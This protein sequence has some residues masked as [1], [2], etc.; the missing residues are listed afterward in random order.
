[1][2]DKIR[3]RQSCT[4]DLVLL[5]AG[6]IL[7]LLL[8]AM[9]ARGQDPMPPM[10]TDNQNAA[11]AIV[12][13]NPAPAPTI[14]G[15]IEEIAAAIGSSTNW[16]IVTGA[17]RGLKGN[18][19]VA[20]ADL[21]YSFNQNVG[22]VGGVDY[23]WAPHQNVDS[24]E[25]VVKGGVT[26]KAPIHPFTFLGSSGG[27]LT[28]VIAEPF[29]AYLI[30]TPT[31]GSQDSVATITTLGINFDL[32]KLKNFELVAGLQYESRSGAGYYDGN[33]ALFH[34]GIGRRF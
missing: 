15:G 14:S 4:L 13:T 6:A 3:Y 24:S 10:P 32:A 30:A 19:N 1:M 22:L 8:L 9:S 21:A 34:L 29:G 16:T 12:A 28:N 33:Y 5:W 17:G 11:N 27:F 2:N 25:N 18:K 31:G 7:C 26:L 20:F 23:L